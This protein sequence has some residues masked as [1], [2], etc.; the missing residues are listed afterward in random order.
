VGLKGGYIM[1]KVYRNELLR[2]V[3]SKKRACQLL[4][5]EREAITI[6]KN[7][8]IIISLDDFD[9]INIDLLIDGEPA[10]GLFDEL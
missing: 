3:I 6:I 9:N 4:G 5:V 1:Q 8:S 2:G 7:K 10:G